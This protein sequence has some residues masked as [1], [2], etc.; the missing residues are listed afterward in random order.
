MIKGSATHDGLN[1]EATLMV[2]KGVAPRDGD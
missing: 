1:F 2:Q